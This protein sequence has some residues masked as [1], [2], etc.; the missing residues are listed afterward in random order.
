MDEQTT[1]DRMQARLQQWRGEHP[2]ASF[3]EI[4]DV[5]QG[6]VARWPAPLVDEVIQAGAPVTA[7]DAPPG[8]AECGGPMQ[9]NGRRTRQVQ[10]R[11]GQPIRLDRDYSVCPACGAGLFPPR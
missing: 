4:E 3:D 11:R 1:V 10:R 2:Q 9:R 7:A 5:V 6:E 8:C